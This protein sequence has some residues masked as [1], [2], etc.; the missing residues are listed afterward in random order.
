MIYI[1]TMSD[2][3]Y[4]QLCNNTLKHEVS[5]GKVRMVCVVCRNIQP[6]GK[7]GTLV[8]GNQGAMSDDKHEHLWRHMVH[9]ITVRTIGPDEK[10]PEDTLQCPKCKY[11]YIKFIMPDSISHY[12]CMKCHHHFLNQ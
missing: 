7:N 10:N 8:R 3:D 9:D 2:D 11:E 6:I 12:V 5:A 1:S 4:C